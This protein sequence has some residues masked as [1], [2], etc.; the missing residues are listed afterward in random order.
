MA[1]AFTLK[2]LGEPTLA[3]G[4]Q[5]HI[6]GLFTGGP[7]NTSQSGSTVRP[8]RSSGTSGMAW[9]AS[10]RFSDFWMRRRQYGGWRN[11]TIGSSCSHAGAVDH[12]PQGC[13]PARLR[14][15]PRPLNDSVLCFVRLC[16][17]S[18][19]SS[20]EAGW[21]NDRIRPN[22]RP[23]RRGDETTINSL[24][25]RYLNHFTDTC[26]YQVTAGSDSW[27]CILVLAI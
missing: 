7:F 24:R 19:S 1:D 4:Q 20:A 17:R 3:G 14:E 21:T 16:L 18:S 25:S 26:S 22:H 23:A 2:A 11:D 27:S 15:L 6:G 13:E 12:V 10:P 5:P 8:S 9:W